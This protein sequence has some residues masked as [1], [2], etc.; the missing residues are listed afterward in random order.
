MSFITRL[1]GGSER[2]RIFHA[3]LDKPE[4]FAAAIQGCVGVFHVAHPLDFGEKESEQVKIERV[5]TGL[6][7]ILRACADAKSV[8]RVVYTSSISAACFSSSGF[9]DEN[10]W[11][12]VEFVRSLRAFG[13]PYFVTKTLAE[14]AALDLAEKLGLDLVSVLPTWITGDERHY[15]YLKKSS[16]VHIED[17]ARAHVHLFEHGEAKGR[18]IVYGVEFKIE[19]LCEFISTRYPEFKI[20][21]AD[22]WKDEDV[23]PAKLVRVSTKKLEETGFKYEYGLEEMFDGAIGTC[24]EKGLLH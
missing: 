1:P 24:K 16:L 7:G 20:P 4:T 12:D 14:K 10:S 22:S 11:T 17:V 15:K 23:V 6:Q 3:D 8:R 21:S 5:T 13:G 2:L 19:E 9:V 18:Y